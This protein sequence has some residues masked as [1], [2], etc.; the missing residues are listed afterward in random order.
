MSK[1]IQL[2]IPTPCHENWNNM[3]PADK[4]RFC[5][6]C[7]KEVVDFTAMS[8]SQLIAFFKKPPT[9]S[10]C[11]RFMDDQLDRQIIEP[12]KKLPW[13]KYFFQFAIPAFLVSSRAYTQGEVK[14]KVAPV[15]SN[16]IKGDTIAFMPA[17]ELAKNKQIKGAVKDRDG[18]P[19]AGCSIYIKETRRGVVADATGNFTLA[20]D[21]SK[22][23]ITLV[24]SAVGFETVEKKI[25]VPA[26]KTEEMILTQLD[27]MLSG[28]VVVIAGMVAPVKK[29]SV[30]LIEKIF[31]DTAFSKFSI[32]P[33]P[34]SPG[35]FVTIK[36]KKLKAGDYTIEL[37]SQSGQFV[38]I[39]SVRL[40]ESQKSVQLKI[41]QVTPGIYF[42]KISGEKLKSIYTEKIIVN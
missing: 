35:S 33:N 14:G 32:Y 30:P 23:L 7:S 10:V 41:P 15:C 5:L 40:A 2:T 27:Y 1:K 3:L 18:N 22:N 21:S 39:E 24:F 6:S 4:G 13:I 37:Q 36:S 28:E 20:V 38:N 25:Q 29:K 26:Y 31:R 34:A 11:G 16:E 8:D 42:I 9:G 12:R 19:I 17:T